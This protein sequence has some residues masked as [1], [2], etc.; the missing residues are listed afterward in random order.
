MDLEFSI[1]ERK[2]LALGDEKLFERVLHNYS[3]WFYTLTF[4][5][6]GE[7]H[8]AMDLIQELSLHLHL[9]F[10]SYDPSL[11][12][13]PWLKT[14][15]TRKALNCLRKWKK[16]EWNREDLEELPLEE[17]PEG[18]GEENRA[19]EMREALSKLSLKYRVPLVLMYQEN[20]TVREIAQWMDLPENTVKTWLRRGRRELKSSLE[21]NLR[22]VE[23]E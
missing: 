23:Q 18:D 20:R 6:T 4:R 8:Q 17:P 1:E 5:M 13:G 10:K 11:P 9:N 19:E 3:S 7:H 12:L 2:G 22:G 21:K 15:S 16:K 14:V